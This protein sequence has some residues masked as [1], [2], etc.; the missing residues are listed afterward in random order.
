MKTTE[1]AFYGKVMLFGEYS[2]I[3]GSKALVTPLKRFSG[4][5]QTGE[6]ITETDRNLFNELESYIRYLK[7]D[8]TADSLLN[9]QLLQKD[10]SDGLWFNSDIPQG[11]GAGS[12]GALVAAIYERYAFFQEKDL[13]VLK[14]NLGHLES[15]FH[16]SS[17]GIDPLCCL[18]RQP[19]LIE[20]EQKIH[21]LAEL[22]SNDRIQG[23]L[24]DSGTTGKT[25]PLV[26]FFH[27]QMHFLSF[28]KKASQQWI[29]SVNQAI[30]SFMNQDK[31]SF[32]S[33]LQLISHFEKEFLKPM[34]PDVVN[35]FW[36]EGSR[37]GDFT[38]KLCGSGGGGFSL[39]FTSDENN[40][41]DHFD[42]STL[43]RII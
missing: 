42:I 10:F 19:I 27:Q 6:I 33:S 26:N 21:C 29:P 43:I 4:H 5:W 17:S 11:Y 14:K 41:N 7:S 38:M 35:H 9:L 32:F 31:A 37:S 40:L 13:Q 24:F 15:Y 22:P 3:V 25:A 23:F 36:E 12:S 1:S 2:V 30:E 20:N 28:Y 18:L 34:I 16:G 8:K 39:V